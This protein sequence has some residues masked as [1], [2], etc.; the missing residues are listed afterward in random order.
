MSNARSYTLA[1]AAAGLIAGLAFAGAHAL[2]ITPIWS[3][4]IGGLLFGVIAGAAAAWAYGELQAEHTPASV[5]SGLR[6]GVML[7]LSVVPVTLVDAALRATGYAYAHRDIT[8]AIAVV[9]AVAGG[10]TLGVLRGPRR[11]ATV[12]C[13]VASLVVTMAMGGPVPVGRNVRTVEILFAVLL[14]SLVG[15]VAV[16]VIE[17]RLRALLTGRRPVSG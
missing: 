12:A 16:G 4:M 10:V 3:R 1:G 15:G 14:A 7:W 17:P 5:A 13:A 8:D 6:F 9:L 11:R 2:I